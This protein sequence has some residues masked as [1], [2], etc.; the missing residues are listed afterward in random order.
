MPTILKDIS[1]SFSEY[2]ILPG[3][4]RRNTRIDDVNLNSK[5][6]SSIDIPLPFLSAAMES[7]SG[8]RLAIALALHGGLAVLPCGNVSIER[9]VNYVKAVKRFKAGFQD[10]VIT[11]KPEQKISEVVEIMNKHGYT[12]FPVVDDSRKLIGLLT[13]ERFHPSRHLD[14][15]VDSRMMILKELKYGYEGTTLTEANLMMAEHGINV[16]PI[17]DKQGILKSVVFRKDLDK[18]KEYP[19][20]F[21]HNVDKRLM[22]GA[23][24][25][26]HPEDLER[27]DELIEA[28]VDILFIDASIGHSEYQEDIIK[29]IKSRYKIPIYGGNV[30]DEEG[31]MFLAKLGVDGIKV[32]QGSGSICTTRRVT[33]HGQGQ[34]STVM[35]CAQARNKFYKKTRK[36]IPICSD[37]SIDGTG[38]MAVAFALGADTIMM[39]KYFAGFTESPTEVIRSKTINDGNGVIRAD[40]KPYW[41][42]ASLRGRNPERYGQDSQWRYVIEG[43]EGYVLH[44]SSI[45]DRNNGLL[46]DIYTLRKAI[47]DSGCLSL[48]E[49]HKKA[50]LKLQSMASFKEG[51]LNIA[52]D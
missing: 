33:A 25:S 6:T 7:V 24:I 42:E 5:L 29:E 8:D 19:N 43:E 18:R 30:V 10:Q 51:S 12:K 1:R 41:G 45:Y 34:A 49:F 47:Y 14:Q 20:S 16:L 35:E 21:I 40:V 38:D 27:A 28:G 50:I 23:A 2:V 17:I 52:R 31:F 4:I 37:G 11:L 9:Q 3:K 22:V 39:G 36:Y 44:K 46:R 26:T 13:K 32:G 15:T 48:Q